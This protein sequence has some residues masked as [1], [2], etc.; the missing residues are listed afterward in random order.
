MKNENS[1]EK[2]IKTEVK[3][4]IN[5]LHKRIFNGSV[6]ETTLNEVLDDIHAVYEKYYL[7]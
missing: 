3:D 4:V 1:K 6:P 7:K 5:T 2:L